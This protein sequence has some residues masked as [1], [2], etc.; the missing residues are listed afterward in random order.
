MNGRRATT[1]PPTTSTGRQSRSR[2]PGC[3][4]TL[5]TACISVSRLETMPRIP[6]FALPILSLLLGAACAVALVSCGGGGDT[7][8]LLPGK[9]AD[10]ILANVDAVQTSVNE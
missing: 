2:R 9:S 6:T 10:A 3:Q 8:G 1:A 5:P 4:S 7:Q